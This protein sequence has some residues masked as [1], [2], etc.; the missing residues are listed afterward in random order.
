MGYPYFAMQFYGECWA[1]KTFAFPAK[2]TSCMDAEFHTCAETGSERICS[3]SNWSN[4]VYFEV[5][6]IALFKVVDY[7]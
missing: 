3:G 7:V 5:Q 2:R 1:G 6:G 4:F